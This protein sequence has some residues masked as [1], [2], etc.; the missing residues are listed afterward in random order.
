MS[1]FCPKVNIQAFRWLDL[2][3]IHS[4][5]GIFIL[6]CRFWIEEGYKTFPY[7][8]VGGGGGPFWEYHIFGTFFK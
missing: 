4:I 5:V 8:F 7:I 3:I 2:A 6:L 1:Q